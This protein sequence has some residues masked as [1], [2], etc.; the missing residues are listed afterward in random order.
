VLKVVSVVDKTGTA[1]DRLAKGVIPYHD[2]L[3]YTVI[4]CHPKRPDDAQLAKF[5]SEAQGADI[6]DFQYFRTA[7]MLLERYPWLRDKKLMLTHN[8]P[9]SLYDANWSEFD[10][11][12]GNNE[13]ITENLSK[14][15]DR[16]VKH[17]PIT[18]NPHFWQFKRQWEPNKTVIMVANRIEGKKGILPVAIAC[19][20]AGLHLILVGAISDRNYFYDIMQTGVVKFYEQITDEE[21]RELYHKSTIHVC[22]SVDNFE[23]GTMP[24]LE[25]MQCGVPV[26]TRKVGHVPDLF[27]GDNLTILEITDNE[28]SQAIQ[29]ALER[30]LADTKALDAQRQS[31]WKTAKN[32]NFERRAYEYQ[33][34]YRLLQSDEPPVSIVV[35]VYDNPHVIRQCLAAVASQRYP[36]I[37]LVVVDDN[38]D[39]NKEVINEF[40]KTVIFPVRYIH[41]AASDN[42]YGLA[43]ARNSGIVEA[44]GDIVVFCDQR[45][46]MAPDAVS[47]LVHNLVPRTWVF[48]DKGGKNDFVEN[49]SAIF[50]DE[51]IRAGMFCERITGYGGMSQEVRSRT[52]MQGIKHVF[53]PGAKATPMGK[54]SNKNAKR[55]EIIR[56]KNRL[57]KMGL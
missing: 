55:D 5:E 45:Q 35:P 51:I 16:E 36:N 52:R 32:F 27:N 15:T 3:E 7:Q 11:L 24:I 38:P 49:F 48:G 26:L 42:D 30:M 31:A 17:V 57:A 12:V 4:D 14:H 41:T 53:V 28:D 22:N 13:E 18:T 37:E 1:L 43:R 39:T 6:I 20:D 9:Y 23:S 50:R 10:M 2:N 19:A 54:S 40:A 8:N 34:L 29:H 44:T 33:R 47:E 21:L 56:M 25:S 46:I